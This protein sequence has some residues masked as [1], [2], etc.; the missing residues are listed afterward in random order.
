MS[1]FG[2][3]L[4]LRRHVRIDRHTVIMT[5]ILACAAATHCVINSTAAMNSM[6][7]LQDRCRCGPLCVCSTVHSRA[8]LL[9]LPSPSR[10]IRYC[11]RV[12]S[13]Q[14]HSSFG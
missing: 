10:K 12:E 5:T 2:I 13:T 9:R 8:R 3:Y 1:Y 14:T 11:V 6:K 4:D 7:I